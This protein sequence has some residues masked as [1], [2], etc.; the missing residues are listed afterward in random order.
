MCFEGNQ[1]IEHERFVVKQSTVENWKWAAIRV[2]K[3]KK[4]L[5]QPNK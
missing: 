3:T 2:K 4:Q 1:H 5:F